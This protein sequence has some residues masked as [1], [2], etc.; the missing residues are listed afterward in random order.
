MVRTGVWCKKDVLILFGPYVMHPLYCGVKCGR[1]CG[2]YCV[3]RTCFISDIM[4]WA[5]VGRGVLVS[6]EPCIAYPF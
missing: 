4:L 1:P 5:I 6:V 2:K 3:L